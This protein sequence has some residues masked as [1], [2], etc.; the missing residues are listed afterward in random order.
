MPSERIVEVPREDTVPSPV[1]VITRRLLYDTTL[2][3]LIVFL[4]LLFCVTVIAVK[5]WGDAHGMPRL[6][7][8]TMPG[9]AKLLF[10]LA[11]FVRSHLQWMRG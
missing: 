1:R 3:A 5:A 6:G 11:V 7:V 2:A 10:L 8:G 4:T 9:I